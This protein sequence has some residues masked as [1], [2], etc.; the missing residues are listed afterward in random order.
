MLSPFPVALR[1]TGVPFLSIPF[2]PRHLGPSLP[3]AYRRSVPAR[4]RSSLRM[5]DGGLMIGWE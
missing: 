2:A 5:R 3:P 1:R 4:K